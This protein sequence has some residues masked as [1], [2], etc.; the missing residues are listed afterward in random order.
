MKTN[1]LQKHNVRGSVLV[2]AMILLVILSIMALSVL[3]VA[4]GAHLR[5]VKQKRETSALVFLHHS[6]KSVQL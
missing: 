2:V 3:K 5:A 1:K 6:R 4:E